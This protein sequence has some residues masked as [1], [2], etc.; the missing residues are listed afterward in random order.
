MVAAATDTDAR[1][2]P[3]DPPR[4]AIDFVSSNMNPLIQ[5][6]GALLSAFCLIA[7]RSHALSADSC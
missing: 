6:S 3:V 1:S 4:Q 7:A 2:S 5:T